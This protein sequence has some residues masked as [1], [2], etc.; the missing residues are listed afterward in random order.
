MRIMKLSILSVLIGVLALT[1]FAGEIADPMRIGVGARPLGMGKA[2]IAVAEDADAI[3]MNPAGLGWADQFKLTSMYSTFMQD[4]NYLVVGGIY[5]IGKYG[6][7]GAGLVNAGVSDIPYKSAAGASLGTGTW[8][9]SVIFVSYGKSLTDK[10]SLGLSLKNYT[11]SAGGSVSS[12]STTS[13]LNSGAASAMAADVG[14]LFKLNPWLNAGLAYQ[15]LINGVNKNDTLS[16]ALKAGVKV[17]IMGENG[18]RKAN[19]RLDLALDADFN[20]VKGMTPMTMH[21]GLEYWPVNSL[22]LRI[23]MDQE[24]GVQVN[25]NLTAGLGIRVGGVEFNYAYHPY[26]AVGT[27][28]DD[29]THFFSMSYVGVP[30]STKSLEL[31]VTAPEDKFVTH[32]S[33]IRVQGNA[34][35]FSKVRV[36]VNGVMANVDDKGDFAIDVPM[37]KLGK[38]LISVVAEDQSGKTK[39]QDLRVLRLA[40]FIDVNQNYWAK[41]P[42]ENTGTV[43]LVQGYPDGTF[44]PDRSLT[45]AELA[46]ILVRAK[47]IEVPQVFGNVFK[48]VNKEH[49]AAG[50]VKAAKT[51]GLVKGYPDG[52]FKPNNKI[53]RIEGIVVM[54]RVDKLPLAEQFGAY[55][56][57]YKDLSAKHW[58]S[59][60]V[61]AAK[62]AGILDFIKDDTL[63]P[64][65]SLSRAESM[66]MFSKTKFAGDQIETLRSWIV[67]FDKE[68]SNLPEIKTDITATEEGKAA[69][70]E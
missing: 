48:D 70:T 35:S 38:K 44:K 7:I 34:S 40:Y 45:R 12:A 22:A 8:N 2:Y 18:L 5:P 61:V 67:G 14:A 31:T 39:E 23:G 17:G 53:N 15:N 3:F 69:K 54:A 47:G 27:V 57:P 59:R 30:T 20:S 10:I 66:E 43:G 26:S 24:P 16:S 13:L 29:N 42:I 6:A 25:T 28:A 4:V 52:N 60:H 19:Q 62:T 36:L 65:L 68:S 41:D 64:K 21:A 46:T 56:A 33:A 37:E 51:Y 11:H 9:S 63:K 55:Q 50:Y 58:S 32:E 1:A 49:W